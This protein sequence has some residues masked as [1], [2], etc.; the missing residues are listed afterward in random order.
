MELTM[1]L[2]RTDITRAIASLERYDYR[3]KET[4]GELEKATMMRERYDALMYYLN[5]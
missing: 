3:I 4:F 1:K 2:D 5:I